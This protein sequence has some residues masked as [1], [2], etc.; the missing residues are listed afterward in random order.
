[1]IKVVIFDADGVLINGK[2]FS[3][4]L[5]RDY[6]ISTDITL[7]FFTGIFKDCIIGKADLKEVLPSY[8]KT[9]GWKKSVDEFLDYW[10]KSEHNIDQEI[11]S[12][13]QTL[14]SRGIICCLATNQEKYRVEYM[15]HKMNFS[16]VFDQVFASAH[17][18]HKKPS[19][20]FYTKVMEK[21]K[22]INKNDVLFWDDTLENVEAAKQFGIHAELY[23]SFSSYKECMEDYL[24]LQ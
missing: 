22:S 17:L 8:L 16:I 18:G 23:T 12:H 13:I 5:A 7:P 4:Q 1:M 14:R 6:G 15:L 21:L 10:F 2:M 11:V 24:K 3:I 19:L 20:E 9:W